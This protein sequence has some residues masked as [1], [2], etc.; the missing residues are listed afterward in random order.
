MTT[1]NA[2]S[3]AI[4]ID[5][6][7]RALADWDNLADYAEDNDLT[8]EEAEREREVKRQLKCDWRPDSIGAA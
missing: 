8:I 3:V 1:P 2:Y 7:E 6:F 5:T 4:D